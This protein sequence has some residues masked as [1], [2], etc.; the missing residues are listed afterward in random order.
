LQADP[1]SA[2]SNTFVVGFGTSVVSVRATTDAA[3]DFEINTIAAPH[4][5]TKASGDSSSSSN[6]TVFIAVG[7]VAALAL[8][9][10]TF[11]ACRRHYTTDT[12]TLYTD[13][14]SPG[15]SR[16]GVS[17]REVMFFFFS[18]YTRR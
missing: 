16:E 12:K 7:A 6:D 11:F 2:D 1:V 14:G 8:I 13:E 10:V 4:L 18:L 9:A 3:A 5:T 15:Q 17:I